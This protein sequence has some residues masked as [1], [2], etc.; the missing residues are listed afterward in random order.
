M[1]PEY[2]INY[3]YSVWCGVEGE[4]S[5]ASIPFLETFEYIIDETESII[6]LFLLYRSLK[7]MEENPSSLSHISEFQRNLLNGLGNIIYPKAEELGKA[8]LKLA[9]KLSRWVFEKSKKFSP[10]HRKIKKV[11]EDFNSEVEN[12]LSPIKRMGIDLDELREY[13]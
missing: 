2:L 13:G 7:H 11:I 8:R 5:I 1:F 4:S 6:P 3:Q 10:N 12:V 9:L